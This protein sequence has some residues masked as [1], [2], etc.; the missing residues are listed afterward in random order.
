MKRGPRPKRRPVI[1][2]VCS[3]IRLGR[4]VRA[5][6]APLVNSVTDVVVRVVTSD[7]VRCSALTAHIVIAAGSSV[8][9]GAGAA[10]VGVG[11]SELCK[12]AGALVVGAL[13]VSAASLLIRRRLGAGSGELR[14]LL[15]STARLVLPAH[16]GIPAA[17]VL[18]LAFDPPRTL[19]AVSAEVTRAALAL[20]ARQGQAALLRLLLCSVPALALALDAHAT[21]NDMQESARFVRHFALTAAAL[22]PPPAEALALPIEL[23]PAP[24]EL[25]PEVFERWPALR[26]SG[27]RQS[28][29]LQS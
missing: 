27:E 3:V 24:A 6:C 1:I 28:C 18:R 14:P 16:A 25:S 13:A 12:L 8:A 21:Y 15:T 7:G 19:A 10:W 9:F 22:C 20:P 23:H 26:A 11:G 4:R 2:L 17:R 29:S 5:T